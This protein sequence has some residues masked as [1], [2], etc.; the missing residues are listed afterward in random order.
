MPPHDRPAGKRPTARRFAAADRIGRILSAPF[1][2]LAYPFRPRVRRGTV[3]ELDLEEGF[4]EVSPESP[5]GVMRARKKAVLRDVV[6]ALHRAAGDERVTALIARV[7]GGPLGLAQVEEVREAVA[8]FRRSGKPALLFSETFGDNGPGHAHYY[9]ATAFDEIYLQPSGELGLGGILIDAPFVK[10]LLDKLEVRP[11]LDHRHEYKNYKNVFTEEGFTEPHREATQAYVDSTYGLLVDAIARGRGLDAE[12]VRESIARGP[13]LADEALE[14]RLVDGLG[15]RDEVYAR[16]EK[17]LDRK[18]RYLY[19]HAYLR[20]AGR[21]FRRGR[22]IALIYGVGQVRRGESEH[23]PLT[24]AAVMGSRTV[25][26]AFRAAVA[27][28]RVEAILFRVDS[29]G[30]SYVASDTIWRETVRAREA[31]KP[32]I[33]SMGNVAGSGG[34]F[35]AMDAHRI[36]AQ[37]STVTGSIG[38]VAGKM[39]TRE[40]WERAGV[41][42]DDVR[43]GGEGTVW[44][45]LHDY[46]EAEWDRLQT[47][48]DRVYDDF[49]AKAAAGR[50][51]S[52]ERVHELARGRIWSG[53]D[54]QRL[55]L[56]DELGGFLTALRLAREAA[57]IPLDADVEL[58]VFPR[59]KPLLERLRGKK[60]TSSEREA[61]AAVATGLEVL[62]PVLREARRAGLLGSS[63][64]LMTPGWWAD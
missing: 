45:S 43:A 51:M 30:G 36:V 33:V 10:R 50:R 5:L 35:V 13:L 54:A 49:T 23:N 18:V 12:S 46:S 48:L 32:V 26:A 8:A 56:V 14:A 6:E 40:L 55:G 22:R 63:G 44:S 62:R 53:V 4:V 29:P 24:G 17:R 42:F 9:L 41:T 15:Y 64:E 27:D 28:D 2:A 38:V 11:R 58:K 61:L 52:R 59:K 19:H 1:R 37:P 20:R 57:D 31:G 25:A 39:V 34:Y 47:I 3:L 16:L 60:P 21:P 7:G